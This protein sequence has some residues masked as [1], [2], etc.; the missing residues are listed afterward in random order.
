MLI[1]N[2]CVYGEK[3]IDHFKLFNG[4]QIL[5]IL[6]QIRR[7]LL[8]SQK[9][10]GKEGAKCAISSLGR[11]ICKPLNRVRA[12]QRTPNTVYDRQSREKKTMRHCRILCST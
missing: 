6:H 7:V 2:L 11:W 12:C 5:S 8:C 10:G 3:L 4:V 9:L 1:T